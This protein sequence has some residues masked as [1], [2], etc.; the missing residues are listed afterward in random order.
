MVSFQRHFLGGR[1][2]ALEALTTGGGTRSIN[3]AFE[4]VLAKAK[5][6]SAHNAHKT[7][8]FSARNRMSILRC[9]PSVPLL[10]A[11]ARHMTG[12]TQGLHTCVCGCVC[13]FPSVNRPIVTG[14]GRER[15]RRRRRRAGLLGGAL[16]F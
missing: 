8:H 5:L 10:A 14:R 7:T 6:V 15:R 16:Q 3:L 13:V 4:A 2:K 12:A 1:S 11:S 9:L